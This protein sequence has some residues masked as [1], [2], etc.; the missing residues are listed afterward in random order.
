MGTFGNV[1]QLPCASPS[2]R[3]VAQPSGTV[4]DRIRFITHHGKQIPFV[5]VS[6]CPPSEVATVARAVPDYVTIEPRN[7]VLLLVDFTGRLLIP[8]LSAR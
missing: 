5:D 6:N 7:S 8:K 3:L 4:T 1:L 2:G